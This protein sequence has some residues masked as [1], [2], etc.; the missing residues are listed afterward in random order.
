MEAAKKEFEGVQKDALNEFE[1]ELHT[2]ELEYTQTLSDK[3]QQWLQVSRDNA[4]AFKATAAQFQ[5]EF[6]AERQSRLDTINSAFEDKKAQMQASYED[7]S[8]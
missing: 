8:E 4:D 2:G 7:V 5:A 6:D 3:E 1:N